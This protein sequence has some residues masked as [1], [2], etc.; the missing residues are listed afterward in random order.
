MSN[1]V[2]WIVE[3][4]DQESASDELSYLILSALEGDAALDEYLSGGQAPEVQRAATEA[5]EVAPVFLRSVEVEGFRGIGPATS[6]D[7]AAKPGLTIVA[8]RNGSG[9]S[10]LSEAL[11]LALTGTTYRW[12]NK[13]AQWRDQWRNLHHR[14]SAVQV[15]FV[16]EGTGDLALRLAWSA[17]ATK[18]D[19]VV[20]VGQRQG[21]KQLSGE[22]PLGWSASVER[23]CPVLS[24]DELGGLLGGAPKDLHEAI[25]KVIG[26][27]QLTDAVKRV[28][29]R[30]EP[31]RKRQT[32]LGQRRR[33]LRSIAG[34]VFD[35]RATRVS[36]LLGKTSPDV[37]SIQALVTG[38]TEP[39][40]GLVAELRRLLAVS[41][42][43][44]ERVARAV[45]ARR[46]AIGAFADSAGAVSQREY[47]RLA[48][49]EHGLRVY[50]EHG[51]MSCPVCQTSRLDDDWAALYR[52]SAATRR[53]EYAD[54]SNAQEALTRAIDRARQLTSV[55]A[56]LP[57]GSPMPELAPAMT[58]VREA[59]DVWSRLPEGE[60]ATLATALADHL[61]RTLP[62][63]TEALDAMQVEAAAE[64]S[65]RDDV[66]QPVAASVAAWCAEYQQWATESERFQLLPE[67][68]KW[69]KRNDLDYRNERLSPI[70]EGAR[71]AW[72]RLR[73]QSNVDIGDLRLVGTGP[74]NRRVQIDTVVDG[75]AAEGI[76]VLSQGELHALA[77]SLFLPR[78]MMSQSPFRFV[79]LDDPVQAM[80]PAKV[81]GL[82]D[83]LADVARTHQVVVF[84]HDDRLPAAIRRRGE[85][86]ARIVEVSRDTESRVR[87]TASDDPANR[88]MSDARALLKDD[89]I[90]EPVQR[91]VL[92]GLLRMAIESAARDRFFT[93]RLRDGATLEEVEQA[94]SEEKSTR[95]RVSLA[96]YGAVQSLD[97]WAAAPYRKFTLVAAGPAMHSG[98]K[99]NVD[100]TQAVHDAQRLIDDVRNGVKS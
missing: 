12:R 71:N 22:D 13:S 75:E 19:E 73:Q 81:D 50:D 35:E 14:D 28:A 16:E 23:F 11:E 37:E 65:R 62:Q 36:T 45:Q 58:R 7:L 76:A 15:R 46:D 57:A 38:V 51:E 93:V 95:G 67:A 97:G 61:E 96:L 24:Y 47:D 54:L 40:D 30:W 3:R 17:E 84:S 94:W 9:K 64:L 78:G 55:R 18:F 32:A 52:E 90:P 83:L 79:V 42:P 1:P 6:L 21:H 10:S 88:H 31:F 33:E 39:A 34:G 92:P 82:V 41:L 59:W 27:G 77:L 26:A 87:L 72:A 60:G 44:H 98:L 29:S 5:V 49:L 66:W 91:R 68:E 48:L 43:D 86:D 99:P 2:D 8:G 25:S 56:D 100:P 89:G 69:L 85:L 53:R 70:R 80:D 63:L 4:L 20:A 74:A